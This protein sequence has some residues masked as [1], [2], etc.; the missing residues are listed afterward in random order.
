MAAP[1]PAAF[2]AWRGPATLG[3]EIRWPP[4]TALPRS[5][6]CRE[7][8]ELQAAR[9]LQEPCT[10][11]DDPH[12]SSCWATRARAV[13]GAVWTPVPAH[14]RT[15]GAAALC[16]KAAW[17][18]CPRPGN[19]PRQPLRSA[20]PAVHEQAT[21]CWHCGGHGA[22]G[23]VKCPRVLCK[24]CFQAGW[25]AAPR[26]WTACANRTPADVPRDGDE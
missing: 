16:P 18:C 23:T 26:C 25:G 8:A 21:S 10:R 24:W 20:F 22:Q 4:A 19:A 15:A 3:A 9:L 11:G 5:P 13:P 14:G 7:R 6:A 17:V 2:A 12:T 1:G